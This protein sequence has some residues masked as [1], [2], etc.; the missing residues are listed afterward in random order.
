MFNFFGASRLVSL[1]SS[2]RPRQKSRGGPS[3][4]HLRPCLE[5]LEDRWVPT[6]VT[7]LNDSGGGSL[8]NAI[9]AGGT[10]TFQAGLHGTID[11]TSGILL[12]T[13]N[14]TIDGPG[15]S[16]ISVNGSGNEGRGIFGI[17]GGTQV[18]ISGLSLVHGE[19]EDDGGTVSDESATGL[20]LTL[21][22]CVLSD[23]IAGGSG[24]AVAMRDGS[25]LVLTGCTL[26]S[27]TAQD[28]GGGTVFTEDIDVAVTNCTITGNNAASEGGGG[29]ETEG[30]AVTVMGSTISHNTTAGEENGGAIASEGGTVTVT[31]S[32][33]TYNTGTD[34]EGAGGGAI[35]SEGGEVTVVRS[36][37]SFNTAA[38]EENGGAIASEGGEVTLTDCTVVGNQSTGTG[39]IS[40]GGTI[41]SEGGSVTLLRSTISNNTVAG[42][43]NGGGID[44]EGGKVMLTDSTISGNKATGSGEDSEGG[45]AINGEDGSIICINST[46]FGN[47]VAGQQGGGGLFLFSR[48]GTITLVNTIVAGNTA[49]NGPGPDIAGLVASADHSLVGD[50]STTGL[51]N[52]H[53][54]NLVGST[55]HTIN[56]RL[57][58]LQNNGGLTPTLAL[59][60][61]SPAI[62]AGDDSVLGSPDNLTTDQRGPGFA[63]K[64]GAHV[65]IGAFEFVPPAPSAHGRRNGPL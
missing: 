64:V 41:S 36:T 10:V 42:D 28:G 48:S 19:V 40:E 27:N 13:Q 24:G 21:D 9:A 50:G 52:G 8:R 56:P 53:N 59:L 34:S 5:A 45:G 18:T 54:G 62:D 55:G 33:L 38:G 30:A 39:N 49:T 57:G 61:G 29:I 58:P 2:R 44:S 7:N 31:D 26:A 25:R 32:T 65:D 20:V 17:T 14:V 16:V 23:N 4:P 12:I 1:L 3:R 47:T 22:A 43:E 37:I 15:A 6:A 63:R 46:I 35:E 11:L 60:A 51:V